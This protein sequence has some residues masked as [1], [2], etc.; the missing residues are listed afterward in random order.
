MTSIFAWQSKILK[1]LFLLTLSFSAKV[2][3][4]RQGIFSAPGNSD[5]SQTKMILTGQK[6]KALKSVL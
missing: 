1:S 4:L 6:D 5:L 2:Y 3:S